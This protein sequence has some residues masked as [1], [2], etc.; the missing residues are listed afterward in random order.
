MLRICDIQYVAN[1]VRVDNI[2]M[3]PCS[4]LF[5]LRK[6][7]LIPGT[8]PL[9]GLENAECTERSP[10]RTNVRIE[11]YLSVLEIICTSVVGEWSEI[12]AEVWSLDAFL[13]ISGRRLLG[14]GT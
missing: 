11:G 1:R 2:E 13:A 5:I 9:V 6:A 7:V 8:S 12:C 4:S 3:P 10:R 14:M